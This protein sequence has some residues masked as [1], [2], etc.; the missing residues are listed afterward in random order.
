MKK[1]LVF[2]VIC[3]AIIS[4]VIVFGD[5][6]NTDN[7]KNSDVFHIRLADPSIYENGLYQESFDITK[8]DYEFRFV[9]N[10]DSPKT[11]TITLLGEYFSFSEDFDLKGTPHQTDISLYYTWDYEGP[12]KIQV[13][14]DQ[15]ISIKINP[16]GNL[17]GSVS[18]EL[19][20]IKQK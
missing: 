7:S 5:M 3:L 6:I 12:K 11:L 19:I 1:K 17:V 16:N 2:G 18:L 8:G 20:P 9:P 10:G 15:R 13:F 14:E 4:A